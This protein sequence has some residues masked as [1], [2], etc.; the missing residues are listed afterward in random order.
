M[1]MSLT[2]Q[3]VAWVAHLSRID[4]SDE[5]AEKMA[6]QLSQ[7]LDYIAQLNEADTANVAPMSHAGGLANV[8]REDAPVPS[9]SPDQALRNAPDRAGDYFRVPRVIE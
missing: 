9:L 7:V 4:L 3:E 6:G 8:F 2:K 5:M 1:T